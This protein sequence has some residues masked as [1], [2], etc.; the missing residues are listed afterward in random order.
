M[1]IYCEISFE[2]RSSL[3]LRDVGAGSA[4]HMV[5][6]SPICSILTS[7]TCAS[8]EGTRLSIMHGYVDSCIVNRN[9]LPQDFDSQTL[10]RSLSSSTALESR[11][12][13]SPDFEIW[14]SG[15]LERVEV[16]GNELFLSWE[17]F[18]NRIISCEGFVDTMTYD[19]EMIYDDLLMLVSGVKKSLAFPALATHL[20]FL[21]LRID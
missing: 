5:H 19:S 1:L 20:N 6:I 12:R 9:D 11:I 16:W 10:S 8:K 13:K 18:E 3:L 21:R 17:F 2:I 15:S 7:A 4:L 14:G